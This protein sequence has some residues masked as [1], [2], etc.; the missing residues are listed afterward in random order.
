MDSIS[1]TSNTRT[2]QDN[3]VLRDSDVHITMNGWSEHHEDIFTEWADKAMCY[4]WLHSRSFKIFSFR[5]ACYT[6]PVIIMSTISG[7]ASFALENI[8]PE[9]KLIAQ[10]AIGTVNISAGILTTI[11][12]FLKVTQLNEAHRVSSVSWGKFCQDIKVEL[13]KHPKD[14]DGP[15]EMLKRFKDEFDRL[16]EISPDIEDSVINEFKCKFGG[17]QK[18]KSTNVEITN[19]C[20]SQFRELFDMQ[21]NNPPTHSTHEMDIESNGRTGHITGVDISDENIESIISTYLK[22]M[23]AYEKS[24]A[25]NPLDY[26]KKP[27]ICDELISTN[28]SRRDWYTMKYDPS[29]IIDNY[30]TSDNNL[31]SDIDLVSDIEMPQIPEETSIEHYRK[32]ILDF[33]SQYVQIQGREPFDNEITD[34]LKDEIPIQIINEIIL[35]CNVRRDDHANVL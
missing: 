13:I 4:R 25:K 21:S 35:E 10:M 3:T 5:N 1:T 22:D 27:D 34:N 17:R 24:K 9:Y 31:V 8:P 6:I 28:E 14:R 29:N 11:Q 30:K 18:T 16:I 15:L 2:I 23:N 33:I 20:V 26:L 12:Q 32:Q 7:T 19:H